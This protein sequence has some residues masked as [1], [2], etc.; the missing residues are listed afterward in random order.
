MEGYGYTY[1]PHFPQMG[2]PDGE[3]PDH[4]DGFGEYY[5]LG[6]LNGDREG[7]RRSRSK[8]RDTKSSRSRSRTVSKSRSR[9]RSRTRTRSRSKSRSRSRSRTRTRSRSRTR[10]LS[11]SKK[12]LNLKEPSILDAFRVLYLTPSKHKKS[13][14]KYLATKK[15]QDRIQELLKSDGLGSKRWLFY[16]R[17]QNRIPIDEVPGTRDNCDQR[18]KIDGDFFRKYKRSNKVDADAPIAKLKRWELVFYK[19]L[20]FIQAV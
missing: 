20:G 16:P 5:G 7:N 15:R 1:P 8:R 18:V 6:P 17:S 11:G 4:G 10:S 2:Y 3:Y 14:T 9:S 13:T 12:E 19:K